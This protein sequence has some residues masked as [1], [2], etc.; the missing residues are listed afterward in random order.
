[1]KGGKDDVAQTTRSCCSTARSQRMDLVTS[2][3]PIFF[4]CLNNNNSVNV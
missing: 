3:F 1:M 4:V 2:F